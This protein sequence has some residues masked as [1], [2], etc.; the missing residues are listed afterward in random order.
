M[1]L[2]RWL[3]LLSVGGC[4]HSF[5]N[6]RRAVS[7]SGEG[8]TIRVERLWTNDAGGDDPSKNNEL[9]PSKSDT[10]RRP[11]RWWN[12]FPRRRSHNNLNNEDRF[13]VAAQDEQEP[14]SRNF[15]WREK[16]LLGRRFQHWRKL[17]KRLVRVVLVVCALI[18]VSPI[19]PWDMAPMNEPWNSG[20]DRP[21]IS[22][23]APSAVVTNVMMGRK[24]AAARSA[25]HDESLALNNAPPVAIL[26]KGSAR[27]IEPVVARKNKVLVEHQLDGS[28][29]EKSGD[30]ETKQNSGSDRRHA[31]LSFVTEAVEKVGPSVVRIDT[32]TSLFGED[33]G[34]STS[35]LVQQGQ[36]SGLIFTSDGFIL[37]NAHVVE[38]VSK[39]TVT[40]MDGRVFEAEVC[41]TDEIVD[42]GTR[43]KRGDLARDSH[44]LLDSCPEDYTRR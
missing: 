13:T 22:R 25:Q 33:S 6:P 23:P 40:L 18:A 1:H 29:N 17:P 5:I 34:L 15:S 14:Q 24:S 10:T 31:L 32:E 26:E 30:M 38:D 28:M 21:A 35:G 16:A 12:L 41:G 7:L 3:V 11:R 19:M 2:L 39:V 4:G 8:L 42:I 9:D 20:D 43:K 44:S 36:G 37:T 27:S